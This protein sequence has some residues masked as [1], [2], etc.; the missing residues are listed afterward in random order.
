M[1]ICKYNSSINQS[2]EARYQ[3]T[4]LYWHLF[5]GMKIELCWNSIQYLY[6]RYSLIISFTNVEGI[7]AIKQYTIFVRYENI[8]IFIRLVRI[9]PFFNRLIKRLITIIVEGVRHCSHQQFRRFS[10][11]KL[12][13]NLFCVY[14]ICI[15]YKY[16]LPSLATVIS[17]RYISFADSMIINIYLNTSHDLVKKTSSGHSLYYLHNVDALFF[18]RIIME[19]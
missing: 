7:L 5:V 3:N 4:C 1:Q 12:N 8:Q 15:I 11:V 13:N 6:C 10:F 17:H 2:R 16:L 9:S 18:Y 19:G 14:C